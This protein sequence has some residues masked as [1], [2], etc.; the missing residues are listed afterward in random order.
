MAYDPPDVSVIIPVCNT[1]QYLSACLDS[2]LGQTFRSFEVICVDDASTDGSGRIL[3]EFVCRDARVK[4]FRTERNRGAG[5][6]RNLGLEK[7]SGTYV[8]FLDSDDFFESSLLERCVA[9]AEETAADIVLFQARTYFDSDGR[10]SQPKYFRAE[11]VR[12]LEVFSWK[13]LPDRIFSLAAPAPWVRFYRRSFLGENGLRFQEIPDSNDLFF[14]MLSM[15]LAERIAG[16]PE[17]LANYR[18]GRPESLQ[19]RRMNTGGMHFIRAFTALYDELNRRDLY[20]ETEQSFQNFVTENCSFVLNTTAS[21]QDRSRVLEAL[22]RDLFPHIGFWDYPAERIRSQKMFYRLQ[23]APEILRMEKR[24]AGPANDAPR[25]AAE[26][27]AA[28]PPRVSVIIPFYNTERYLGECLRSVCAQTLREIEILC[29]DDG[30][31]NG[32]PEIVRAYAERDPRVRM[33]SQENLGPAAA[34]NCGLSAAKGEYIL[35]ADS[36]DLLVRTDAAELLYRRASGDRLDVLFFDCEAFPDGAENVDPEQYSAY[37]RRSGEYAG[38]FPG[39][40]LLSRMNGAGDYLC[41]PCLQMIRRAHLTERAI[42][43]LPGICHEDEAFTFETCLKAERAGYCAETF[44]RRRLRPDSI[45]TSAEKPEHAVGYWMSA[46]AVWHLLHQAD[47]PDPCQSQL[48]KIPA[49]LLAG[50]RRAY[51]ALSAKDRCVYYALPDS[52]RLRF[53]ADVVDAVERQEKAERYRREAARQRKRA[54]KLSASLGRIRASRAYRFG[55]L[56]ARPVRFLKDRMSGKK[57]GGAEKG[58]KT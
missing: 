19:W 33:L 17:A 16:I 2:I 57:R 35:F 23:A 9:K 51:Q 43:F 30:S 49:R 56:A 24:L 32:S 48:A 11:W 4:V 1:E 10:F 47:L 31:D 54:E 58:G 55:T 13:D 6:A 34:R 20:R 27:E 18:S 26:T 3:E 12:D 46:D 52:A 25:L 53:E 14:T 37:Y 40:E 21:R 39:A 36:D 50:A 7:A 38:V 22:A 45:M 8:I 42:R 28:A 29:V 44:Y 5:A 15:R 41:S